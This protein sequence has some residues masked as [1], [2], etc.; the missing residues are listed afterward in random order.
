MPSIDKFVQIYRAFDKGFSRDEVSKQA[1]VS[2]RN[3]DRALLLRREHE[4]GASLSQ[5]IERTGWKSPSADN[6]L[7][8]LEVLKTGEVGSLSRP[9]IIRDVALELSE[10]IGVPITRD[11][12]GP[13][14][15]VWIGHGLYG[16]IKQQPKLHVEQKNE[17]RIFD[18][19]IPE[20]LRKSFALF[21]QALMSYGSSIKAMHHVCSSNLPKKLDG[22]N[23]VRIPELAK[24]AAVLSMLHWLLQPHKKGETY[25]S[26]ARRELLPKS[27]NTTNVILGAWLIETREKVVTEHLFLELLDCSEIILK[28]RE[29]EFFR[30]NYSSAVRATER[31]RANLFDLLS[32]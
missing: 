15:D 28:S 21:R 19:D 3:V 26:V 18:D 20:S 13:K 8:A 29:A 23:I 5:I 12:L 9:K 30:R 14:S 4:R 27:I 31:L 10:L 24:E 11:V 22:P 17:W 7:L 1:G 32:S 6:G 2:I 16:A 25:S